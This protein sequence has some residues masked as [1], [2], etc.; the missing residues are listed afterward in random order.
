MVIALRIGSCLI[1]CFI[2]QRF[3]KKVDLAFCLLQTSNGLL[4]A[5]GCVSKKRLEAFGE[6][7]ESGVCALGRSGVASGHDFLAGLFNEKGE[8]LLIGIAG[9]CYSFIRKKKNS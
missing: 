9:S 6:F 1:L 4:T 8:F 5:V 7:V 3:K 2:L